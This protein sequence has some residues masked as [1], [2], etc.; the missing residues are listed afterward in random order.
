MGTP[1]GT[2][3]GIWQ[4]GAGIA[5][6]NNNNI[7]VATGDGTFDASTGGID[8]GDTLVKMD[9]FLNVVDYF[10]PMDQACRFTSDFDLASGGPM[11]LPPQPG[12][13]A[14]EILMAGKG[15]LPCDSAGAAP[16]YLINAASMGGYNPN[17]DQVV[18]EISGST[19]GYWSNPAYFQGATGTWVYYGGVN[20]DHATGD[21]LKAYSVTNGQLSTTPTSQSSNVLPNGATPSIS[22]NGTSN[23]IAWVVSRQDFLDTR[24]GT[25]PAT[26]YAYDATN[27]AT[28]LYSSAQSTQFGKR[29]QAGCGT[30]FQVPTIAN[31]K[32]YVGTESELDVYALLNQPLAAYPVILSAPCANFG[33]VNVGSTGKAQQITVKNNGPGNLTFNSLTIGGT[34]ASEFSQTNTCAGSLAP[35][36]SC[37]ITLNFTPANTGPRFASVTIS[38][39]A[40]TPQ[41]VY[42]IGNGASSVTLTPA[43]LSFGTISVGKSSQPQPATLQNT[44]TSSVTVNSILVSGIDNKDFTQRNNCPGTLVAGA[45]CTINVT[46]TP[47]AIG[48]RNA[49]LSVNTSAGPT[50]KVTLSGTGQ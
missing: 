12:P 42:L 6:D 20:K 46:F 13:V 8:Y 40:I 4:S 19:I 49:S 41:T 37:T 18:Q 9:P 25:L 3:G 30:K 14:N 17:Q 22:A 39:S 10:T 29:D 38:D 21:N 26:L 32:V 11:I 28:Q 16:I 27:L 43:T 15:G 48:N 36:K 1:N 7:Y 45:S 35:G 2:L 33:S 47:I 50:L 5:A 34:N 31:G 24:P 23:G 44:G